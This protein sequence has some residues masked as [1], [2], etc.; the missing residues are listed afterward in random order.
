MQH[1]V[2]AAFEVSQLSSCLRP[3]VHSSKAGSLVS[4]SVTVSASQPP[5]PMGST[6]SSAKRK[7]SG[8]TPA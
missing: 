8:E 7:H 4:G 6:R 3:Q 2:P 5:Q 1:A